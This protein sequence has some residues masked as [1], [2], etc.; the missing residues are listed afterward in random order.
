MLRLISTN[1]KDQFTQVTEELK[2]LCHQLGDERL[3]Y[4]AWGNQ[5]TYEATHQN[6]IGAEEIA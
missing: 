2:N 1:D 5:S 3:F 4:T 6:Y